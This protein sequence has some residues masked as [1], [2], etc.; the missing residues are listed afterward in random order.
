[1]IM[2]PHIVPD[3]V[4]WFNPRGRNGVLTWGGPWASTAPYG[5]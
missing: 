1:M 3:V 5:G 4:L 2:R